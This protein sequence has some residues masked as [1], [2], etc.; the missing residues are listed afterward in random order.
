MK[1]FTR[2]I[3]LA[4]TLLVM[5]CLAVALSMAAPA[6]ASSVS[7]ETPLQSAAAPTVGPLTLAQAFAATEQVKANAEDVTPA[8]CSAVTITSL[9]N[10]RLVSAEFGYGSSD[11]RYGMLRARAT[12][13]GPWEEFYVCFNGSNSTIQSLHDGS[14]VSAELGYGTSDYRWGM[15]RSRASSAGAWERYTFASCGTDCVTIQSSTSFHRFVSAELGYG[16]TDYRWGM[17]RA[18]ATTV[19]AWERFR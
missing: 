5:L 14:Y 12:S 13:E 17:L 8:A 16:S 19:G 6:S 10:G 3:L 18:R 15:L 4:P 9:A 11:W 2:K 7:A 1:T